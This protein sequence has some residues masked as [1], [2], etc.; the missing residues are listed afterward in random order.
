MN[1]PMQR[2]VIICLTVF[3]CAVVLVAGVVALLGDATANDHLTNVLEATAI[4]IAGGLLTWLVASMSQVKQN[5]NGTQ[6]QLQQS[7][8]E[9]ARVLAQAQPVPPEAVQAA[10][11]PEPAEVGK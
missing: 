4:P 8:M 6:T 3:S 7:M 9:L 11:A 1:S 10:K 5:T 2:L